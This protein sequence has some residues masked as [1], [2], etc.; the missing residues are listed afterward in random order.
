M[1]L[2]LSVLVMFN[3]VKIVPVEVKKMA[4]KDIQKTPALTK[5][6]FT[7]NQNDPDIYYIVFDEMAGFESMREYWQYSGV[8]QFVSF[9]NSKGFYVAENSHSRTANTFYELASRLN[10]QSYP[11]DPTIP[12]KYWEVYFD[13]FDENRVMQY[14][15]ERGYTIIVFDEGSPLTAKF[16]VDYL[17]QTSMNDMLSW[18]SLFD[19]F[20]VL[21]FRNTMLAPF[22]EN[23]GVSDPAIRQHER[24]LHF[25]LNELSNLDAPSP[26]FVFVHLLIPHLPFLYDA[27]GNYIDAKERNDWDKYLGYY[28]FAIQYAE[29]MLNNIFNTIDSSSP[30]VVIFQSDHGARNVELE[31]GNVLLKNYPS[32]Y[33][34]DIVNALYLPNCN[35]TALTQDMNPINT[36]PIVFNCYFDAKIPLK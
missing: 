22:V 31:M 6:N 15:R 34:T 29:K 9:L 33:Q 35:T 25:T 7:T 11:Y 3:L 18:G 20:G 21:V 13:A 19:D 5:T 14:L 23:S 32:K 26:K 28:I 36:F 1:T 4:I 10:Y 27:N 8:D 12:R 2:I 16:K 17:Y 24:M 30:P